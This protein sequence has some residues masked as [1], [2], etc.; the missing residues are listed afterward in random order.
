MSGRPARFTKA[1]MRRAG[2][3]ALELGMSVEVTPDG[4]IRMV[5]VDKPENRLVRLEPRKEIVL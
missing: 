5:P 3:V 4:T 2:K 1:D